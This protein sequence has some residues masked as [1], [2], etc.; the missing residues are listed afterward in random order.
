MK[1]ENAARLCLDEI[2]RREAEKTSTEHG[3]GLD[4][5]FLNS[6][7]RLHLLCG[8]ALHLSGDLEASQQTLKDAYSSLLRKGFRMSIRRKKMKL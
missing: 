8:R 7:A 6:I 4:K 2:M 3:D 5:Y 1:Y